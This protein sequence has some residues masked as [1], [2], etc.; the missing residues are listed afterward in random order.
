[1]GRGWR[2]KGGLRLLNPDIDTVH[3]AGAR[4]QSAHE[5]LGIDLRTL[6]RWKAIRAR[7]HIDQRWVLA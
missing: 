7:E 3:Y 4:L 5:I 2:L 1:M 6:Q